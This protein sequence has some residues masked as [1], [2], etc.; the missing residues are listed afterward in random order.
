MT[1]EIISF[2]SIDN[3]PEDGEYMASKVR[4]LCCLDLNN[5][6]LSKNA[7]M[8]SKRIFAWFIKKKCCLICF[9]NNDDLIYFCL[10]SPLKIYDTDQKSS[11]YSVLND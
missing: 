10:L 4:L 5:P 2:R 8:V 7:K 9:H 1:D 6:S 11:A 3:R